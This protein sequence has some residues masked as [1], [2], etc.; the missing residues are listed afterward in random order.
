M[1][2]KV[3]LI[4]LSLS[5]LF[6]AAVAQEQQTV[7]DN[8]ISSYEEEWID[9][10][11]AEPDADEFVKFY[12]VRPDELSESGDRATLTTGHYHPKH[13]FYAWIVSTFREP[14]AHGLSSKYLMVVFDSYVNL[15][16]DRTRIYSDQWQVWMSGG[17][18][19]DF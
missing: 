14:Y 18:G 6:T 17:A 7:R 13:L 9:K 12:S 2:T 10:F 11:D 4:L 19:N 3:L 16:L 15:C 1:K 8:K 5:L